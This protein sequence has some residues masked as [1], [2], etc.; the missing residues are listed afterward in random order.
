MVRQ[1]ELI[2]EDFMGDS[3]NTHGTEVSTKIQ[4]ESF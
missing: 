3:R 2:E 1:D 4:L